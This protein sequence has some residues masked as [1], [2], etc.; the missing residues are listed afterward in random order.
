MEET[1]NL[2]NVV[3]FAGLFWGMRRAFFAWV[4]PSIWI[5]YPALTRGIAAKTGRPFLS[6]ASVLRTLWTVFPS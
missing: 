5:F 1:Q 2:T 4:H 3:D 6:S